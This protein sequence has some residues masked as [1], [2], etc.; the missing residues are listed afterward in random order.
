MDKKHLVVEL[1][2]EVRVS[3]SPT[4]LLETAWLK[5]RCIKKGSTHISADRPRKVARKPDE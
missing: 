5:P 1:P 2:S 3:Q 4:V